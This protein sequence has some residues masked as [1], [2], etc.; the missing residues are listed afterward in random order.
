MEEGK[1]E[2]RKRMS[3]E[4]G[5]KEAGLVVLQRLQCG[6]EEV[7]NLKKVITHKF[8]QSFL[9][10]KEPRSRRA[11]GTRSTGVFMFTLLLPVRS[12]PLVSVC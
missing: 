6:K 11:K 7:E 2:E 10:N 3:E 1:S 9:T 5:R 4:N 12:I 8:P